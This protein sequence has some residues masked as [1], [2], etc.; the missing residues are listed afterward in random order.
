[1]QCSKAIRAD[2][3]RSFKS[4]LSMACEDKVLYL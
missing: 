3:K 1:M 2:K 4:G